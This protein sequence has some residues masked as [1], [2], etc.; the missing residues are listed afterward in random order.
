MSKQ[1]VISIGKKVL[2]FLFI[3]VIIFLLAR[4][5]NIDE[6]LIVI[7][8]MD[9]IYFLPAALIYFST[10]F[11][12]GF[13][14]QLLLH[15]FGKIAFL[16]SVMVTVAGF[17]INLIMPARAGEFARAWMLN[18]RSSITGVHIFATVVVERIYDGLT[19]VLILV[20]TL[21]FAP[22][23]SDYQYAATI[24]SALFLTLFVFTLS[25]GFMQWPKVL[26]KFVFKYLPRK[27]H[28][29]EELLDTFFSSLHSGTP[30][31]VI[32]L[33]LLSFLIWGVEAGVYIIVM[34]AFGL[35]ITLIRVLISLAAANLGML[36]AP[37]P[38]GIGVFQA[39][40]TE[41]L[42][43]TGVPFEQALAISIAVH[44]T[45]LIVIAAVGIPSAIYYGGFKKAR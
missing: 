29:I 10:F 18:R 33:L 20:V 17:G 6:L 35:Q 5:V 8:K 19:I 28:K 36:V 12:R 45:Q 24:L 42:M 41:A 15:P 2:P 9:W 44:A 34:Q 43:L 32:R 25:A 26:L 21:Y 39:A 11:I 27:L 22:F 3:A 30:M 4:K 14:W 16:T 40:M 37:T 13:R 31:T 23:K 7:Q 1:S 38:G